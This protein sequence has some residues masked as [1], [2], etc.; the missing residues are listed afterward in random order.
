MTTQR[1]IH[2]LIKELAVKYKLTIKQTREI[3]MSE[4]FYLKSEISKGEKNK[5][6]TFKNTLLKHLGTFY[7][8]EGKIHHMSE[9]AKSKE[10]GQ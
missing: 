7:A 2:N 6:P 10:N 4:F 3:V 9:I 1:E 5:Y 8:S